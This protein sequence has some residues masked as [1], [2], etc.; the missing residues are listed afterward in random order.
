MLQAASRAN[1]FE[2]IKAYPLC[3]EL[4][5]ESSVVGARIAKANLLGLTVPDQSKPKCGQA[6]RHDGAGRG[7][8]V[9]TAS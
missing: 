4:L 2:V 5:H 3:N 7:P 9:F 8:K 1:E 6:Q